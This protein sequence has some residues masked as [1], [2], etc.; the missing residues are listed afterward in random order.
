MDFINNLIDFVLPRFCPSCGLKL[1]PVEK[2]VCSS[3]IN[4]IK[5]A[6]DDRIKFEF[7]KK[8]KDKKLISGFTSLYIFEKDKELQR[9]IHQLKYNRRFLIGTF[10]GEMI[11]EIKKEVILSWGIDCIVPVPLHNLKKSERGY[12]QSLYLA[13]GIGKHLSISVRNEYVKRKKYTLTQTK[14]NL[15]ERENNI[16]DAFKL[17]RNSK[18][19]GRNILLVDDVITTGATTNE[20]AK[21][22][23]GGGAEKVFAVSA[24]IAE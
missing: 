12:N 17:K 7:D 9:I 5:P 18:L 8:Y 22:L 4:Q 2:T 6:T 15:K 21:V 16:T 23:I 20:C 13:K 11:G 3:C 19:N 24:A 10:L 14:M 1:A